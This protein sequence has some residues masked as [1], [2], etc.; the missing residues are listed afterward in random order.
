[1]VSRGTDLVSLRCARRPPLIMDSVLITADMA[2]AHHT[3]TTQH[4]Y[5]DKIRNF[6]FNTLRKE[7]SAGKNTHGSYLRLHIYFDMDHNKCG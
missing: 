6:L 7:E 3:C 4:I 2:P 1:M 5:V